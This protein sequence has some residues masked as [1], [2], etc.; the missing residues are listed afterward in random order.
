MVYGVRFDTLYLNV[1]LE[2]GPPETGDILH[3]SFEDRKKLLI[4][5][6]DDPNITRELRFTEE[7]D[8]I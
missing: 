6:I 4:C 2:P 7:V 3:L 1:D 5:N 8:M